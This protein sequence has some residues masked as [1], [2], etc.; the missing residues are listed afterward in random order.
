[1]VGSPS[2]GEF[3]QFGFPQFNDIGVTLN[4]PIYLP[5]SLLSSV[6]MV[7][8]TEAVWQ[9]R[10]PLNTTDVAI[11]NA[12][13]DKNTINSLVA[14]DL[15]GLYAPWLTKTGTLSANLEWNQFSILGYGKNLVYD[16][17]AER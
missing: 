2:T 9:D 17:Y 7:L 13:V 10:T 16:F 3:L 5:G 4:R 15:D 11:K 14:L 6:P 1:M 12:V 8:R